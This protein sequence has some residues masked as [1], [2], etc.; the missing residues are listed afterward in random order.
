MAFAQTSRGRVH[1]KLEGMDGAPTLVLLNSIGT[2]MDLWD[3]LLP[4]WP[5]WLMRCLPRWML[6][7]FPMLRWQAS[8]WGA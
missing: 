3:T 1:W 7:V 2:D 5:T 6:Q 8:R 4:C